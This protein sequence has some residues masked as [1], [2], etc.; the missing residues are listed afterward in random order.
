M[1]IALALNSIPLTNNTAYIQENFKDEEELLTYA[2]PS[3]D[4]VRNKVE[5]VF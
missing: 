5:K 3:W 2:P 4:A 1:F